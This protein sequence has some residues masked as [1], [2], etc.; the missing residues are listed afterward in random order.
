METVGV[1][2]DKDLLQGYSKILEVDILLS[3]SHNVDDPEIFNCSSLYLS[4]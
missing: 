3:S 2:I 1:R 4:L